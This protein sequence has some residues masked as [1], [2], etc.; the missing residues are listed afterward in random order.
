MY[1]YIHMYRQRCIHVANMYIHIMYACMYIHVYNTYADM[2]V[3]INIYI[4]IYV[5]I[6]LYVGHSSA[7]SLR[8]TSRGI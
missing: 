8:I 2:Y 6:Y 7:G 3:Y 4:Y 1:T 5:F